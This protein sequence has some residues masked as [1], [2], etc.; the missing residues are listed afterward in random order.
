MT[1]NELIAD[2]IEKVVGQI[3]TEFGSVVPTAS[4]YSILYNPH[5]HASWFIVIY[6]SDTTQLRDGLKNEVC[7]QMHSYLLA[8]IDMIGLKIG[9]AIFFDYGHQPTE[10]S[11]ID[12][13]YRTL[14]S[15]MEGLQKTYGKADVKICGSCGHDFDK[16]QLLC[17]G[18][19][20]KVDITTEGWM[21]CPEDNCNCFST[22]SINYKAE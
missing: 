16:H 22:W 20:G 10:K 7:Y 5:K 6:F 14:L 13:L 11:D 21:I 3:F 4:E 2:K 12:N 17:T 8:Q 9:L 18:M 1:D 15:K 19:N